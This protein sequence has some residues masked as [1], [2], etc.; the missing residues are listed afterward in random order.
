MA[1]DSEATQLMVADGAQRYPCIP[2][3][4]VSWAASLS[5][6]VTDEVLRPTP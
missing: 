2:F 4:S 3:F 6:A 1:S 5:L